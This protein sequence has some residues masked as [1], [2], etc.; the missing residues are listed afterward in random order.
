MGEFCTVESPPFGIKMGQFSIVKF[1]PTVV[2]WTPG[3][4]RRELHGQKTEWHVVADCSDSLWAGF[5]QP[6]ENSFKQN[7]RVKMV[8]S[9]V[10]G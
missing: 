9:V 4:Y 5:G 1:L 3:R 6:Q 2:S 8:Q 10:T 7:T